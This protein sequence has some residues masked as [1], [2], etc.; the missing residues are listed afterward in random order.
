MCER[1]VSDG[2]VEIS[3]SP[4]ANRP[5]KTTPMAASSFTR[6]VRRTTPMS[7]TAPAP[8][9]NAPIPNGIPMM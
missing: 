7:A 5:V 1:S 3:T 8:N 2:V 9:T 6:D 4:S